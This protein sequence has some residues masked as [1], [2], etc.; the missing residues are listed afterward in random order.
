MHAKKHIEIGT[1]ALCSVVLV[2]SDFIAPLRHPK[3]SSS[4]VNKSM[5]LLTVFADL[6]KMFPRYHIIHG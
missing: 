6:I 4:F 3:G 5:R 2:M 1:L